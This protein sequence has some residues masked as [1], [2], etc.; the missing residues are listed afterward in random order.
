MAL[1][2]LVGAITIPLPGIGR[3]ALGL[4]G[5]LI[6]ALILGN[7]RR[8]AGLNW[9]VP[10]SA[11]LVLR[12]LDTGGEFPGHIIRRLGRPTWRHSGSPNTVLKDLETHVDRLLLNSPPVSTLGLPCS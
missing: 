11:N 3:I 1:G 5:L 6:V 9:T 12:N 4:A 2:F 10:L 8:V 7:Q